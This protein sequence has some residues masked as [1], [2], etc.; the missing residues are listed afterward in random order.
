MQE[1]YL[2]YLWEFQKWKHSGLFTTEGA[3]VTVLSAGSH[4][5]LSGPD[6][7]N[8]RVVIGDQEWA[9]N[10]EIHINSSDWYRHR[11]EI[12][13]AYDNVILHVV[14]KH[15]VD[16][17]RKDQSAVP[18]L[19]L[20][21]IVPK[22][23][24]ENYERLLLRPAGNWIN[25]ESDFKGFEEFTLDNWLE[26]LYFERL[27]SKSKLIYSLLQ[28]SAG[29]WEEVLFKMLARNFGLNLNGEA[30]LSIAESIPFAVVRKCRGDRDNLEALL[31]GQAGLLE[32]DL[33]DSYYLKLKQDYLFLKQKY[34]LSREGISPVKYFRLRPDNFPELR[35]VQL[36]AVYKLTPALFS[37]LMEAGNVEELRELFTGGIN[38]YWKTH[39][40]FR[41]SHPSRKKA[42][43]TS[44]LNLLIINTLVPVKFC[45]LQQQGREED[46][47]LINIMT[48]LP[49]ESN[50]IIQKFNELR[51]G[52]ATNALQ[53]Q[54]LLQLKKEYCD[55]N[56]CLHC[57]L[58]IKLLQRQA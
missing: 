20:H 13:P 42:F 7:F 54:A 2:H 3:P 38:E 14:W 52:T 31:L 48:S 16:V 55:K 22:S 33:E 45:Y 58:G 44:F 43:T 46:E 35:L 29:N 56:N 37:K 41:R 12:D 17:Y 51:T 19:E 15:D 50:K 32:G 5:F 49:A 6:F 11:H 25:C 30:F 47:T 9:G 21:N 1:D 26:R 40:T 34:R 23:T 8:S 27:E 57:G 28:R 53:S 4:N 18:V 36:A 39:Y 10:V 24:L